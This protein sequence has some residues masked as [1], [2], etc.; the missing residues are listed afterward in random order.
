MKIEIIGSYNNLGEP[1]LYIYKDDFPIEGYPDTPEGE[2]KANQH[3]E[4]LKSKAKFE[5]KTVIKS[6]DSENE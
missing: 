3:F 5:Q 6:W 4:N 2:K 1:T